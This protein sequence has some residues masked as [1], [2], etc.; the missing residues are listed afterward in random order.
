MLYR[1]AWCYERGNYL[2]NRPLGEQLFGM[3][4]CSDSQDWVYKHYHFKLGLPNEENM[5]PVQLYTPDIAIGNMITKLGFGGTIIY[6]AFYISLVLFFWKYRKCNVL[7]LLMSAYSIILMIELFSGSA[8]SEV[9][10]L[11]L[12][13][14]IMSL[15]FHPYGEGLMA[16]DASKA[17]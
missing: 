2:V 7:F 15:A 13:F 11:S 4:L 6:L 8:L 9:K 3:G 10:T 17:K 1:F 12:M 16:F 14:F 5:L